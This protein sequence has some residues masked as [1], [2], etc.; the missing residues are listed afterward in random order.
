[1]HL[2]KPITH[3]AGETAK[4]TNRN[5]AIGYFQTQKAGGSLLVRYSKAANNIVSFSHA[6]IINT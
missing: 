2:Y 4:R 1:M 5:V 3:Y 6:I